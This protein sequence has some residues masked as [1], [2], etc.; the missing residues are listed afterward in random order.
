MLGDPY[1]HNRDTS[2]QA[3]IVLDIVNKI[4]CIAVLLATIW[5]VTA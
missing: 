2:E 4:A 5:S 1:W 3:F